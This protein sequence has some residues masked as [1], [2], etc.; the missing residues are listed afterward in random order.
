MKIKDLYEQVRDGVIISD[1]ELQR[2]I[3]Y[4][5]DKQALVIDSIMNDIPLPAF[6]FWKNE[7]DDLEVLD[8]KQRIEAIRKFKE[9]DLEYN[10]LIW[11]QEDED[12][13]NKFNDTDLSVI[14]CN[15]NK[16]KDEQLK[17]EIFKRINM[18]GVPLSPFEILNG[19]CSGE[20]L[21]GLTAYVSN[22]KDCLRIL[23]D[24]G[25]GKRQM[26]ILKYLS[27]LKNIKDITDYVKQNQN[28]SFAND[29]R[30]IDKYVDFVSSVFDEFGQLDIY[31]TL[32]FKYVKDISIWKENKDE[33]NIRVKK[34]LRSDDV[35]L[36]DKKKEIDD[37]IQAIVKGISVDPKRLFTAEQKDEYLSQKT[38][39]EEGKY[40]CEQ[41]DG[42]GKWFYPDEL[43]MDHKEAWSKG[44]RTELSNAQLL[45]RVCNIKKNN[46]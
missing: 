29:Q 4:K 45:C 27:Q 22:D 23:G 20:Y 44:G 40:Q 14:I 18:L 37:I 30:E 1:I 41:P 17:R 19:M 32:A 43:Q 2:E 7:N 12:F 38:P 46:K 26:R 42:C 39:N 10:G 6:Y 16:D 21:R 5:D 11:K 13:Q 8:G 24:G 28:K 25:R 33:I 31:M 34:Y 15:E 3:I 36:T 9:N 35:K